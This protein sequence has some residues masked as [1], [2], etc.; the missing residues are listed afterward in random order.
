[1]QRLQRA[2]LATQVLSDGF[3]ALERDLVAIE[4][5]NLEVCVL[6]EVLHYDV[7]SV[8]SQSVFTDAQ[9]LQSLVVLE[10]LAKMNGH[11]LADRSVNRVV[12]VK[13]H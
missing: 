3:T 2:R 7:D 8:I 9:L 10:H 5:E 6:Q 11:R 13:L 12:D 4:I 1:M